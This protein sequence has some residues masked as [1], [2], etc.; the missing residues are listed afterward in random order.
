MTENS[1]ELPLDDLV[2]LAGAL[3]E[4][5]RIENLHLS[6]AVSNQPR[7]LEHVC[8][9][10]NG[11]PMHA[12]HLRQKFMSHIETLALNAIVDHFE[13]ATQTYIDGVQPIAR[14]RL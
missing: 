7:L 8:C 9:D 5:G 3:L 13:P 14:R 6:S 12:Q 1:V 11:G 10:A 2:A 4:A